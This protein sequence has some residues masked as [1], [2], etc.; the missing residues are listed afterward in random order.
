MEN[1]IHARGTRAGTKAG[2]LLVVLWNVPACVPHAENE[3]FANSIHARGTRA[4][5][6]A[7]DSL[8]DLW[9]VPACVLARGEWNCKIPLTPAG[10]GRVHS[11]EATSANT[12]GSNLLPS[13]RSPRP[14]A[15][16]ARA[17]RR[18]A[19]T[20]RRCEGC[21]CAS[22]WRYLSKNMRC[23]H[24]QDIEIWTGVH[25][26]NYQCG[27]VSILVIDGRTVFLVQCQYAN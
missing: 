1:S 10:R 7:G 20:N 6:K 22:K 25:F 13:P 23:L 3:E 21:R 26:G 8:A 12:A 19:A 18:R 14:N 15:S 17:A 4:G 11:M 5:T 16:A 24:F 27:Q 2:D 9:T